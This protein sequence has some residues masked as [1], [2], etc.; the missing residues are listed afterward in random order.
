MK[1]AHAAA[2]LSRGCYR[3]PGGF[4]V[5][6]TLKALAQSGLQDQQ[7]FTTY[8]FCG[9]TFRV[10]LQTNLG[11]KMFWRGAHS[12]P[13]IFVLQSM[14]RPGFV[15]ADLGAN[16]GEYTLWMSKLA[17]PSGEVHYFEPSPK[18]I[19]QL[20][21]VLSLN[22]QQAANTTVHPFGM[23]DADEEVILYL[24]KA[25]S[26]S[27]NEGAATV[28]RTSEDDQVLAT[29]PLK[30]S[31]KAFES[32]TKRPIDFIKLDIEGCEMRAL[33]GMSKMLQRDR[34][35]LLVEVNRWALNSAGSSPEE[36][37]SF[38]ENLGYELYLIEQRGRLKKISTSSLTT[39][40]DVNI[41]ARAK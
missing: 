10:E 36:L 30:E 25:G 31:G 16:Q 33:A 13:P 20:R 24:P 17:G 26:Q 6:K 29:I 38:L 8:R 40:S 23:S 22:L 37:G 21:E 32:A 4:F 3:I 11:A 15:C 7:G 34:P 19:E 35:I 2:A 14:I 5:A 41:V 27:A 9:M 1:F 18:M 12:W 28:F 39:V